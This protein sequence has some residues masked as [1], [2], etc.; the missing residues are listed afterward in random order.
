MCTCR[1]D[2]N[3]ALPTPPPPPPS[4]PFSL[5]PGLLRVA[6]F[7]IVI[8]R[9][10]FPLSSPKGVHAV[11]TSTLSTNPAST[12]YLSIYTNVSL[13]NLSTI[14]LSIYLLPIYQ[15]TVDL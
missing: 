14:Y 13:S 1:T 9:F 6:N 12:V 8:F 15:A 4:Q 11:Y 10:Y 5:Q 2:P 7:V 3:V